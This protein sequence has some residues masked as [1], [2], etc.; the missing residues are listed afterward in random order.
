MPFC[1]LLQLPILAVV[2]SAI[3]AAA[4]RPRWAASSLASTQTWH[5]RCGC[6][7]DWLTECPAQGQAALVLSLAQVPSPPL[8]VTHSHTCTWLPWPSW[9]LRLRLRDPFKWISAKYIIIFSCRRVFHSS[10]YLK[11]FHTHI[12]IY[13][14]HISIYRNLCILQIVLHVVLHSIVAFID[15]QKASYCNSLSRILC[16]N[17]SLLVASA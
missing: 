6:M 11:A 10:D 2:Q 13:M 12:Y 17:C 5:R 14:V 16:A 7:T 9:R 15:A 4:G 1:T 3:D 8:S